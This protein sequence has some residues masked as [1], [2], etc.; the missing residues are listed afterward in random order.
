MNIISEILNQEDKEK[1][2]LRDVSIF[3]FT[4]MGEGM[5]WGGVNTCN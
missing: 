3:K 2:D 5:E 4:R 1:Q